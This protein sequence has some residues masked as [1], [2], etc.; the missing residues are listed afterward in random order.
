MKI[1]LLVSACLCATSV[2]TAFAAEN[3]AFSFIGKLSTLGITAEMAYAN[4]D[5]TELFSNISAFTYNKDLTVEGSTF[6]ADSRLM[7]LIAGMR[8]YPTASNLYIGG[9]FGINNNEVVLSPNLTNDS[10]VFNGRT[11]DAD[12]VS[13]VKPRAIYNTFAPMF[14]VG[15]QSKK[16]NETGVSF[17]GEA[18]VFYNGDT[19]VESDAPCSSLTASCAQLKEDFEKS[20][21]ALEDKLDDYS[22]YPVLSL[23]VRYSF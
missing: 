18:G 9:G 12:D 15:W 1:K 20:R 22:I 11:Y 10:Y 2:S 17:F 19:D 3:N 6:N 5:H 23:G 13:D 16:I 4:S 21:A 8:Y 14:M 7:S